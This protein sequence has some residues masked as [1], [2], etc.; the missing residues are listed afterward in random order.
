MRNALR[1]VLVGL[2][3]L[4]VLF[5]VAGEAA[6]GTTTGNHCLS[7]GRT[8][9]DDVNSQNFR[10]TFIQTAAD[11]I[12][13]CTPDAGPENVP[14]GSSF[15]FVCQS[16]TG[17]PVPPLGPDT[18]VVRGY[19]ENTGYG[20]GAGQIWELTLSL[21]AQCPDDA[22]GTTL[23]R[24]CTS[25]GTSTGSPRYGIVRVWVRMARSLTYDVHSEDGAA[26]NDAADVGYVRCT[27]PVS[28][29][30]DA[31]AGSSSPTTYVG[32]DT[33]RTS[34]TA[35]ATLYN[36]GSVA[37][38]RLICG[39]SG[40]GT[41]AFTPST[42]ATVRDEVLR[43][44]PTTWP[45]D[46]T[47]KQEAAITRKTNIP[48]PT[49]GFPI[50]DS[51]Y[52]KWAAS[53]LPGGVTLSDSA[54][55]ATRDAKVLDRTLSKVPA[56]DSGVVD[57]A[58]PNGND[59]T[60]VGSP[61][62]V[63]S[64]FKSSPQS[65]DFPGSTAS[66][67]SLSD[68][69][70]IDPPVGAPDNQKFS[71]CGW[72]WL[73]ADSST[74]WL[75]K[76]HGSWGV[77]YRADV[78][79][80]DGRVTKETSPTQEVTVF[81]PGSVPVTAGAW[82]S[83]CF[84]WDFLASPPGGRHDGNLYV[85]GV[86]GAGNDGGD[87]DYLRNS[88]DPLEVGRGR[89]STMVT[90]NP[91]L[92]CDCKLDRI[93]V[94][95]GVALSAAQVTDFHNGNPPAGAAVI[96]EFDEATS[97]QC[98]ARLSGTPVTLVHR[99]EAPTLTCDW[100]NARSEIVPTG[101]LGTGFARRTT[102]FSTTDFQSG[103]FSFASGGRAVAIATATTV[104]VATAGGALD[105]V[106]EVKQ[107]SATART[108]AELEN[109]GASPGLLD[110]SATWTWASLRTAKNPGN[111]DVTT[112][113]I[114]EDPLYLTPLGLRN[115]RGELLAGKTVSCEKRDPNNMVT[116]TKDHT[117]TDASGN[118]VEHAYLVVAPKGLWTFSC[119][120]S[121]DGNTGTLSETVTFVS[122]VSS[123]ADAAFLFFKAG[124]SNV[125][126]TV[127]LRKWD[128][129]N[130][131]P[132]FPTGGSPRLWLERRD[133]GTQAWTSVASNAPMTQ[134]GSDSVWYATV[135][136]PSGQNTILA[137]VRFVEN[138]L[139]YVR[140]SPESQADFTTLTD[141]TLKTS[142]DSYVPLLIWGGAFVLFLWLGA[143][144]PATSAAMNLLATL[145][146]TPVYGL[147]GQV[148]LIVLSLF[149]H[150]VVRRRSSLLKVKEES[151]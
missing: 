57:D 20:G 144:L 62:R 59:G 138:G 145:P 21:P 98:D 79:R 107:F 19:T 51:D 94:Y 13:S 42:T 101:R 58:S 147:A 2:G 135:A 120:A 46:C 96:W 49:W 80:I 75:L 123:K 129:S 140:M 34:F 148:M 149:A 151:V 38:L 142:L 14:A 106:L 111:S 131:V 26:G 104:A 110:V 71:A 117:P 44:S 130:V 60:V 83:W 77:W 141:V 125:N 4:V 23:T 69:D 137:E 56:A 31:R 18:V 68:R 91:E 143:W 1:W 41:F 81:G 114:G 54:R 65:M 116:E 78:D 150:A 102:Q 63:T 29:F 139:D 39:A 43:G 11:P 87:G 86:N 37:T 24:W 133:P 121:G 97:P 90:T 124:G 146:A 103:D 45:D 67:V 73:D 64:H 112:F 7:A 36:G 95:D 30:T 119:T 48:T 84:V 105:Y 15:S 92:P 89:D 66:Y 126:V 27:A 16:D 132:L 127:T 17:G 40:S 5:V 74:Q 52:T 113:V 109:W 93:Y 53:G 10:H 8:I 88:A 25:D 76:K 82:F 85:N 128:G 61:T 22:F 12:P 47:V 70:A 100:Q 3:V 115:A 9:F 99:G 134:L 108:D 32:G 50:G 122:P 35:G 33:L 28:A 136:L 6:A 118:G 55:K 72:V